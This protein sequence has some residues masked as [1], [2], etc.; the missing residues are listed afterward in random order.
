MVFFVIYTNRK[1]AISPRLPISVSALDG[2]CQKLFFV[3]VEFFIYIRAH[4]DYQRNAE[5][6]LFVLLA[7]KYPR[8]H[9][10]HPSS[11]GV[12]VCRRDPR[13]GCGYRAEPRPFEHLG[14]GGIP[15]VGGNQNMQ[16][17]M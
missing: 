15:G 3:L 10:A 8:M 16:T 6:L 9:T 4:V 1:K 2:L 12:A 14:G 13:A 5:P 11:I 17:V 7:G